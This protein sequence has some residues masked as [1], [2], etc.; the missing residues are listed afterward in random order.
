MT[1]ATGQYYFNDNN[2]AGGLHRHANYTLRLDNPYDYEFTGPLIGTQSTPVRA[3][4]N[5]AIDSD[6][7]MTGQLP[8]IEL[9]T[10][11]GGHNDHNADFGI[12]ISL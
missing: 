12:Y 11:D 2:V 3:G 7:Q 1:S 4:A 6:A 5:P 9:V 8:H 10:G